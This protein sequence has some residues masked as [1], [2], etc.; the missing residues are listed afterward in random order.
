MRKIIFLIA[1]IIVGCTQMQDTDKTDE[2]V[3]LWYFTDIAC[4]EDGVEQRVSTDREYILFE[5]DGTGFFDSKPILWERD[6][7]FLL[8]SDQLTEESEYVEIKT[9]S[10]KI[11]VLYWQVETEH[12][13]WERFETYRKVK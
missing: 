9:I 13:L 12:Y 1:V 10:D 8:L 6:Y 5:E 2:I 7:Q 11:L 3:G 4:Y